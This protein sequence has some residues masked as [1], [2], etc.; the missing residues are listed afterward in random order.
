MSAQMDH[1]NALQVR[2]AHERGYL[3][4]AKNDR[5]RAFRTQQIA[6]VEKEISG[7]YKFLGIAQPSLDEILLSDDELLAELMAP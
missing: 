6:Q 3:A 7:E 2:L 4:A 5:A 1:L